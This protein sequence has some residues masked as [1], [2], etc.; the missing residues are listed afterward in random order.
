MNP[1]KR[2]L[3]KHD[4]RDLAHVFGIRHTPECRAGSPKGCGRAYVCICDFALRIEAAVMAVAF[5]GAE[6]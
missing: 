1:K 6:A 3:D 4:V 2:G 5:D